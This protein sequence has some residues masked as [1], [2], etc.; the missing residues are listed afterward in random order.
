[1][2]LPLR[3]VFAHPTVR[4]LARVLEIAGSNQI[5]YDPLL[6]LRT[7]GS[8]P[9][10]FCIHPASGSSTVFSNLVKLL[11]NDLPVYGMQAKFLSDPEAGHCSI[12]EMAAC[13]IKAIRNVQP[14]G[15]YRLL[16]WSFGGVVLQEMAAQL[17][18]QGE[19]LE[20]AILLDSALKGDVFSVEEAKSEL[21]LIVALADAMGIAVG[22]LSEQLLKVEL[23]NAIKRRGLMASTADM[24]DVNLMLKM[25]EQVPTLMANWLGFNQ[26]NASIAYI[27]ASDNT[28]P[29]LQERLYSMTSGIADVFDVQA[30]H[31]KMC[32]FIHSPRIA[33]L[34]KRILK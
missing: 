16:G 5:E 2:E 21:E 6:P 26:L 20:V 28:T 32:D 22:Q 19:K 25:M 29:F 4:A 17:E 10:L 12:R 23:L 7:E 14:I 30:Q 33:L 1:V 27:R 24:S 3:S 8:K 15:P 34:V 31:N 13:Y 9:P 11:P 18:E